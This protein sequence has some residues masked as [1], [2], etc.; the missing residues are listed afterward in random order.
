[1]SSVYRIPL[2]IVFY[3]DDGAMI[4]HC[5]EFDLLGD[6]ATQDEAL[7]AL[8]D[9]IAMQV[10]WTVEN[11]DPSQL[12]SPA[13]AVYEEMFAAGDDVVDDRLRLQ[14]TI[15]S[16]SPRYEFG[17]PMLRTFSRTAESPVAM[18]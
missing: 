4:A 1:M 5:L 2:R 12:F 3:Q 15:E 17:A 16:P 9:A 8:N 14:V 11:D 18:A 13:P 7:R 6:G 10:Q